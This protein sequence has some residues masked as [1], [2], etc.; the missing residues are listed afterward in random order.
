MRLGGS[1]EHGV[2]VTADPAGLS[3]VLSNLV[4]NAIRHTPA[5]GA[6]EIRGRAVPDG[7]RAQRHR[8]CGGIA[9][10]DLRGS[11]TSPGSGEPARTPDPEGAVAGA[12]G[13][14]GP[15]HREGHRRGAPGRVEVENVDAPAPA[16][17][18]FRVLL[19]A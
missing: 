12:G 7:R 4:M 11:S 6:V 10:E 13:R 18:R 8:R 9:A 16:G 2:E 1:V 3:R 17:C 15:G 5:D 19:P 14:A